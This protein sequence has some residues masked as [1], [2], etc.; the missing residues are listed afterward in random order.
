MEDKKPKT[1]A[2]LPLIG[3]RAARGSVI[4][5]P[6]YDAD[7]FRI[8][9]LPD[10]V[11]NPQSQA[12]YVVAAAPEMEYQYPDLVLFHPFLANKVVVDGREF[13][14]VSDSNIVASVVDRELVPRYGTAL[15]AP[16][17]SEFDAKSPMG[18]LHLP[19]QT[20][21]NEIVPPTYGTVLKVGTGTIEVAEGDRVVIPKIGGVE[22]GWIDRN[23]YLIPQGL[24]LATV[25]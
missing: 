16:D 9:Y 25:G 7:Y 5:D 2:I 19:P 18:L 6:I 20:A 1:R 10:S 13:L 4:V 14:A 23:L 8:F 11:R 24:I 17:W 3:A 21:R 12:G 22:I 15:V